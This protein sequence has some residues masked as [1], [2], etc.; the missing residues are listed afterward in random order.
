MP[1]INQTLTRILGLL[2]KLKKNIKRIIAARKM[3]KGNLI[4]GWALLVFVCFRDNSMS[5]RSVSSRH[6]W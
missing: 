5:F 4:C 1:F 2:W 6:A 3:D